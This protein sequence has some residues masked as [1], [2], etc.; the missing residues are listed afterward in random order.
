[1]KK[2]LL[3]FILF[4]TL[5]IAQNKRFIYE[6]KFI[7]D[8]KNASDVKTEMMFLD[9]SKDG[10][11]YYSYTVFNSDSLLKADTEKQLRVS[12][13]AFVNPV[14]QKGAVRYSVTK[15]Y[16]DYKTN[17][18][19]RMGVYSY[20]IPEDRKINWKISSE[21]EKIGEW[22]TQKAEADFAGRHWIAWFSTE[23]P[24]QDGPYKFYGLPGL[25]IK[26][27]NETN[28]HKL[29]L[30]GIKNIDEKINVSIVQPK[31]IAINSKKFQK[32]VKDQ[33]SR[34]N[35]QIKIN[36]DQIELDILK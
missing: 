18:H 33:E 34:Q 32:L 16:P 23:I 10:S 6:Y 36:D 14:F 3:L 7:A 31:E 9:T 17:I 19:H 13:S 1:M 28:S 24:I 29:E 25:I 5:A 11:R 8:S 27:E 15:T 4:G 30:K 12:D 21:K 26:I 35:N 20:K 2:L 22:N